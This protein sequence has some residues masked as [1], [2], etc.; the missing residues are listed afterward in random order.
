VVFFALVVASGYEYGGGISKMLDVGVGSCVA[1]K[2]DVL[3]DGYDV[4]YDVGCC[5]GC[6]KLLLKRGVSAPNADENGDAA[7][8]GAYCG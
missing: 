2:P 1:S 6:E 3:L 4:G 8:A 5:V 7:D